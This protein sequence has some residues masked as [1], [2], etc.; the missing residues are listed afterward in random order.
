MLAAAGAK[1]V[2]ENSGNFGSVEGEGEGFL[3][4][5]TIR[6]HKRLVTS[7]GRDHVRQVAYSHSLYRYEFAGPNIWY[8]LRCPMASCRYGAANRRS[9]KQAIKVQLREFCRDGVQCAI[10]IELKMDLDLWIF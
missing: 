3:V 4:R 10:K 6:N 5:V 1:E 9:A 8:V 7:T 2:F